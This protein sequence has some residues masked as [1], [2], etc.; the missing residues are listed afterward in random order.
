MLLL[1]GGNGREC[2]FTEGEDDVKHRL[3]G[4]RGVGRVTTT[5]VVV[6]AACHHR[7]V[8]E[9]GGGMSLTRTP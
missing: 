2:A 1:D 5:A 9:G 4:A 8:E 6:A 3:E 7:L